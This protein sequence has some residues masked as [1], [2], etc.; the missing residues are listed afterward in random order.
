MRRGWC[1][2]FGF[3]KNALM[4]TLGVVVRNVRIVESFEREVADEARRAGLGPLRK[5][6]GRRRHRNDASAPEA[7]APDDAPSEPG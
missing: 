6:R 2:L 1:R 3:T 7:P 5:R 4:Y